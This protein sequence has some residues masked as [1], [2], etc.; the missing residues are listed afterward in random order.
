[1]PLSSSNA[2]RQLS[3]A[4]SQGTVL[5]QSATDLIGFYGVTTAVAKS[6][7]N[8]SSLS[9]SSGALASSM[10]IYFNSLGLLTCTTVLP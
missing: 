3:D 8:F 10:A 2:Q 9:A 4:N 6:T 1:M 5:G 7:V